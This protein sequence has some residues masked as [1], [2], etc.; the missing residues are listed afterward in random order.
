MSAPHPITEWINQLKA[1][2]AVAAQKLWEQY[3]QRMVQLA[4]R[5]L[6]Q[7]PRASADEEDVALSA[8]KSFCLG[9][10]EGRFTQL[11]DSDNLWPLLMAITV[12]KSVDLIRGEN[13]QKRGGAGR[14]TSADLAGS[15]SSPV[16]LSDIISREPTVEFT[17]EMTEQLDRLLVKLDATGDS[18]LQRIALMKLEGYNAAEISESIGCATRTI[19][20]KTKLI[21]QLWERDDE[22]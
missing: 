11:L 18:D 1:G 14:A 15:R 2:D 12:Y 22:R 9:A 17:A 20:R 5:K 16:S 6:G 8:F 13:R 19:E 21:A 3:F 7:Q 10:R 4:R